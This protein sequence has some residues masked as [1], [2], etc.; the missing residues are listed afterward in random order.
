MSLDVARH[1]QGGPGAFV[2]RKRELAELEAGVES[3]IAGR[4]GLYLVAGQAGIGKTRL[5]E[6]LASRAAARNVVPL[7][8]RAWE[9]EGAPSFW[10]WVQ[11]V[12]AYL[13]NAGAETAARDLGPWAPWV[14]QIAP[15]VR[16]SLPDVPPPPTPLDSDSSRFHLFDAMTSFLQAASVSR[17]LLLIFDDLQWADAPSLLLLQFLAKQIHDSCLLV[18][19]TYREVEA[20]ETPAVLELLATL[21]YLARHVP[22]RGLAE[23]EVGRFLAAMSHRPAPEAVVR[24]I[25]RVTEGNPF[26]VDEVVRLFLAE[27]EL[28][29]WDEAALASVPIPRAVREAI[30][31]R[32][33]PLPESCRAALASAS[34]LGREFELAVLTAA[35]GLAPAEA[36]NVIAPALESG[37][38]SRVRGSPGRC[39]FAHALVREALYDALPPSEASRLH[40]SIAEIL[41]Q[42]YGDRPELHL[43]ELAHHFSAA[44]A[45]GGAGKAIDYAK[46]AGD[47]AMTLLAYEDAAAQYERALQLLPLETAAPPEGR[48]WLLLALGEAQNRSGRYAEARHSLAAATDVARGIGVPVLLGQAAL[49]LSTVGPRALTEPWH[50]DEAIVSLLRDALDRLPDGDDLLRARLLARLAPELYWIAGGLR[51]SDALARQAIAMARRLGDRATLAQALLARGI[52][53][54]SLD[55]IGERIA[56]AREILD[57]PEAEREREHAVIALLWRIGDRFELGDASTLETDVPAVIRLIEELREPRYLW[58]ARGLEAE[59][60]L[61]RGRFEEVERLAPE[62]LAAGESAQIVRAFVGALFFVLRREQ[63]RLGELGDMIRRYVAE[64]PHAHAWRAGLACLLY[65]T[66]QE[67]EARAE[68]EAVERIG[69]EHLPRDMTWP[70]VI[71]LFA[72]TC[73]G[74]GDG[75]RAARLHELLLPYRDR[76]VLI[77]DATA[78]FLGP[79]AYYLGLLATAAARLDEAVGDLGRAID[80]CARLGA[81]PF[82]ARA[83]L[84]CATALLRRA[85]PADRA[86]AL[87]LVDEARDT[88]RALGMARLLADADRIVH[89]HGAPRGLVGETTCGPPADARRGVF[90]REGQLWLLEYH[91][92]AARIPDAKGLRLLAWLLRSPGESMH[93]LELA[94]A[95]EGAAG[96]LPSRARPEAG[97]GVGAGDAGTLLDPRAKHEYRERIE[98]LRSELEQ[99]ESFNDVGRIERVR[100]EIEFVER[101][102]AAAVGLGGRDRRAKSPAERARLN[103]TRTIQAAIRRIGESHPELGAHLESTVRTGTF[104]TYEP[105]RP[106]SVAWEV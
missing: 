24:T 15:E 34:A 56:I 2:G 102:L 29:E 78:F 35:C 86:R 89:G 82:L 62:I 30:R 12:R 77:G 9:G 60:A 87:S 83:R 21:A 42:R 70:T 99:A 45:S 38:L 68:I 104:C 57:Q 19:G 11:I 36:L 90:R 8:S 20:R 66:G 64:R 46:R 6:E 44:A 81:L 92:R 41:E 55:D 40:R 18:V 26:F 14:A 71:A 103:V 59:L 23:D 48:G 1:H 73:A 54:G 7:W 22:L 33:E 94:S 61:M 105:D 27:R 28:A 65:E 95:I 3:A 4:G 51:E 101:E 88:A 76:N 50:S 10:P 13:R 52:S 37:I 31:R 84:A 74:L 32:L 58:Q 106:P 25:H 80:A 53:I 98:D 96:S 39:A 17:T 93:A 100:A 5:A 43:P 97:L 91:G 79:V 72:E 85:A 16:S 49:A 63:G 47:R 69:F 75:R 67:A